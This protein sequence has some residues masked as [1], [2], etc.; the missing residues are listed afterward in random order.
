MM[1]ITNGDK[2]K[3]REHRTKEQELKTIINNNQIRAM[4]K[5]NLKYK[6]YKKFQR[7]SKKNPVALCDV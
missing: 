4:T 7:S 1:D 2:K 3:H 5:K 6:P